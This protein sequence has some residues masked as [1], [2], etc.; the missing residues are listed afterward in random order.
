MW[1]GD[2]NEYMNVL[3]CKTYFFIIVGMKAII[4]AAGEG[5][6]L[7]PLTLNTPKPLLKVA[8]QELLGHLVEKF[9]SEIDELII[10]VGY[11]GDKIVKHCGRNFSGRPVRYVWQKDRLGTYHALKL[12]EPLLEA[13][14]RFGLFLPDDL[15]EKEAIESLF[16]HDLAVMAKEVPD[17]RRFGVVELNP[18]NSV[19]AIEEKPENPKT[20]LALTSGYVL[21][22]NVLDYAP[23]RGRGGEYYLSWSIGKMAEDFKINVVRA[24]FWFPIATPEDLK[25]AELL[26]KIKK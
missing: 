11:L 19:R 26:L 10:V 4:L 6:R 9:P 16:K 24:N 20:N 5:V 15:L 8:G 2:E 23:P 17:P 3:I 25:K 22:K 21:N 1:H 7:R 18:D 14:E 12:C 13:N